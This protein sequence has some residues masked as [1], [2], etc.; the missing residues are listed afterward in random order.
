MKERSSYIYTLPVPA[1]KKKLYSKT[2]LYLL[3]VPIV[4]LGL[5][6]QFISFSVFGEVLYAILFCAASAPLIV[7]GYK[8]DAFTQE[9]KR[10]ICE[11]E[12]IPV[13]KIKSIRYDK[14]TSRI[15]FILTQ[16]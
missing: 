12:G 9:C 2:Y 15:I 6:Y 14:T 1:K 13:D 4:F 5:A 10:K 3:L 16:S 8:R 11:E 7:F